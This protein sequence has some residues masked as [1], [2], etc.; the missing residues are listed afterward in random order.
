MYVCVLP[1]CDS[2]TALTLAL[3]YPLAEPLYFLG[4]LK[5]DRI[6]NLGI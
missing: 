5:G 2:Q 6:P 1:E 3:S 4:N